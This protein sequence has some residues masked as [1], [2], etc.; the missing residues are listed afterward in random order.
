MRVLGRCCAARPCLGRGK[1]IR[2]PWRMASLCAAFLE[3]AEILHVGDHFRIVCALGGEVCC[4]ADG[5]SL[6]HARASESLSSS[7]KLPSSTAERAS[8]VI[9]RS[10]ASER[11]PAASREK[12]CMSDSR[13]ELSSRL[14]PE[15]RQVGCSVRGKIQSCW[16]T[17][18]ELSSTST[19]R[20]LRSPLNSF[21]FLVT[22]RATRMRARCPLH[23]SSRSSRRSR[24]SRG[25]RVLG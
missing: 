13:S 3:D 17:L 10:L 23:M 19:P 22:E 1:G 15:T 16:R 24:T 12:L 2:R 18:A 7:E 20:L 4:H 21:S 6:S 9:L 11:C 8:S 14:S 25:A 5:L